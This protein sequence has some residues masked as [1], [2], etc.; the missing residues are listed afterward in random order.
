MSDRVMSRYPSAEPA[1]LPP[2]TMFDT[3]LVDSWMRNNRLNG[4]ALTG[5]HA[6]VII[7]YATSAAP[8]S[9]VPTTNFRVGVHTVSA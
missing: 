8:S 4:V 1:A 9:A 5:R 6:R 3:A 2:G 7:E